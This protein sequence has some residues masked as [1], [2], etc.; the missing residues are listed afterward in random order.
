MYDDI[1]SVT[2]PSGKEIPALGLG[3]WNMGEMRSSAPQEVESI[4]KAIDLGMTLIDTAEMYA[5]GRSE[6]VVGTAIAGR[7][8]EV[9]LVSKVYPWNASA[10]GTIEACERSLARLGTDR[11]DLYLLHWR[12][13]HP[14]EET[15]AAFEKL[16]KPARSATGASRISTPTTWRSFSLFPT[17]RIAPQIRCSTISPGADRNFRFCPGVSGTACR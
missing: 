9:F 16:K 14:L 12:G 13:D 4:R 11:L 8:D 1:P 3:T 5:D 2:L 15:V 7:R 10:R 17:V 6:E